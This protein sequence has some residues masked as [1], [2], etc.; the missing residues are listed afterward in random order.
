MKRQTSASGPQVLVAQAACARHDERW[1]VGWRITNATSF[2][3]RL[4]DARIPHGRFLGEPVQLH[5]VLPPSDGTDLDAVVAC[6]GAQGDVVE[7]AFLIVTVEW[8]QARWRILV[9][10]TVRFGPDG[11]PWTATERVTVQQVGF[12][13]IRAETGRRDPNGSQVQGGRKET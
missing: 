9:R 2:E 13:G 11:A 4:L 12:S 8:R 5:R 1:R 7:N 3:M 6:N 10:M